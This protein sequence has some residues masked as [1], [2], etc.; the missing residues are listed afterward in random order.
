VAVIPEA[1]HTSEQVEQ[2]NDEN[3]RGV[4]PLLVV[5]LQPHT[6]SLFAVVAIFNLQLLGRS[7]GPVDYLY[8]AISSIIAV[9]ATI[10]FQVR[11]TSS[12]FPWSFF[13]STY[14][15]HSDLFHVAMDVYGEELEVMGM[16]IN[17]FA[18]VQLFRSKKPKEKPSPAAKT[19][20]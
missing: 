9:I 8:I 6:V 16:M 18:A 15:R 5:M 19:L 14:R 10:E 7:L 20:E 3:Q 17:N 12:P 1:L 4:L 2:F 13:P 11:W